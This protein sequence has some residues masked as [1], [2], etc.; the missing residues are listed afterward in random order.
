MSRAPALWLVSSALLIALSVP[1]QAQGEAP[2]S[3]STGEQAERANESSRG[4]EWSLDLFGRLQADTGT[5]DVP[6]SLG[7]GEGA[8]QEIRRARLGVSGE[9]PHGLGYKVEL[10]FVSGSPEL[11]DAILTYEQDALTITAGQHNSFQSLE[12]LTSS[13]FSSFIERA[14]FTDAFGFERRLGVSAQHSSGDL[15]VQAGIFTDNI[16]EVTGKSWSIDGRAVYSP[17]RGG[18][19]L[20]FAGSLH[21]ADK[22]AGEAL[23]YRQRPLVHFTS[24]RPIDTDDFSAS[25]EFAAGAEA[26]LISGPLHL[27][28]ETYWQSVR[29]PGDASAADFFGGY[30][31]AGLYLTKGDTRGYKDGKFD[32]TRPASPITEGGVGAVQINLRYDYLDLVDA[33]I[34]GGR[35]NGYLASLVWIPTAYTRLLLTY[36]RLEYDNAALA[37]PAGGTSYAADVLGVRAQ[38][39]F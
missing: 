36:G 25:S 3:P 19:Q 24:I 5:L 37:L 7:P 17:K 38:V 23:R 32:R 21:Y 2:L 34:V 35:Q 39:D 11:T 8:G 4:D 30:A 18:T 31:E 6:D 16:E 13:R 14:A 12:E 33:A 9:M 15:L 10:E 20:H 27:A 1:A 26:A 28:G 29:R 22:E